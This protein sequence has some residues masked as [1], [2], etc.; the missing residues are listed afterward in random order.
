MN[1]WCGQLRHCC[2]HKLFVVFCWRGGGGDKRKAIIHHFQRK[3]WITT[4][5]VELHNASVEESKASKD[6]AEEGTEID[7]SPFAR[8]A[9]FRRCFLYA[10][11]DA[12]V[13]D[14]DVG[15]Y[16]E[17]VRDDFSKLGLH[18]MSWQ[19]FLESLMPWSV[20]DSSCPSPCSLSF[21]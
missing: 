1:Q 17:D 20:L 3:L 12:T 9:A 8:S 15:D 18:D 4:E 16:P 19:V 14:V 10:I 7:A 6:H 5:I 2:N 11:E 13:H 21:V